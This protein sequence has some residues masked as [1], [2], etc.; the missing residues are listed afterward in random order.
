MPP[1]PLAAGA[2]GLGIEQ[3]RKTP[4]GH[5]DACKPHT[6]RG[7]TRSGQPPLTRGAP[8]GRLAHQP[9]TGTS[10]PGRRRSR[11]DAAPT[12]TGEGAGRRE[13][14]SGERQSAAGQPGTSAPR[15]SRRG[16]RP[17]R[18][19]SP[20]RAERSCQGGPRGSGLALPP[21]ARRAHQAAR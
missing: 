8:G 20:P 16:A 5:R 12:A 3:K 21:T 10:T 7:R 6:P 2:T 9:Q 15:H 4:L 13:S 18:P 19:G 11:E 17:S 14:A 1:T